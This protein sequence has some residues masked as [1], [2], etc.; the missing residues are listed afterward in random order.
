MLL[1]L[2]ASSGRFCI[3]VTAAHRSSNRRRYSHAVGMVRSKLGTAWG[4]FQTP[5]GE[6]KLPGP[7]PDSGGCYITGAPFR[8]RT[9]PLPPPRMITTVSAHMLLTMAELHMFA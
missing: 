9:R 7:S 2:P 4:Q 8:R 3:V 5:H 1:N 6:E